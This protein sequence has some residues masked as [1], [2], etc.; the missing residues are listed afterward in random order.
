MPVSWLIVE[1]MRAL[2]I[3]LIACCAIS[4][5]T[6]A[7][8]Q[9][10]LS[11]LERVAKAKPSTGT[12]STNPVISWRND[13]EKFT[14]SSGTQAPDAAAAQWMDLL[15]RFYKLTAEQFNDAIGQGGQVGISTLIQA[16][17]PT[18]AWNK[19]GGLLNKQV[20]DAG[21]NRS[22]DTWAVRLLAGIINND[23]AGLDKTVTDFKEH[24]AALDDLD[25]YERRNYEMRID[26]VEDAVDH[27]AG[28][29]SRAVPR[30]LSTLTKLEKLGTREIAESYYSLDV[31]LLE[32]E[33]SAEET[34]AALKRFLK[35]GLKQFSIR[36]DSTR[37]LA[38]E[39]AVE[40]ADVLTAAPWALVKELGNGLLFEKLEKKFGAQI[41]EY[42]YIQAESDYVHYLI[43]TNRSQEAVDRIMASLKRKQNSQISL[44][45]YN[46]KSEDGQR[47]SVQL[48]NFL[49]ALL[50][51]KPEAPY[52]DDYISLSAKHQQSERAL[53]DLRVALE[54]PGVDPA[55]QRVLKPHMSVAL[56]AADERE[57]GIQALVETVKLGA[58]EKSLRE[59]NSNF[60]DTCLQLINLGRLLQRPELKQ[61]ALQSAKAAFINMNEYRKGNEITSLCDNLISN[62]YLEEAEAILAD[63]LV[64][65]KQAP[66]TNNYSGRNEY[67]ELLGRLLRIYDQANRG[68]ELLAL[69][70]QSPDWSR[71]DLADY[72]GQNSFSDKTLAGVGRAL[73]KADRKAEAAKLA[74][75]LVWSRPALDDGYQL[76]LDT[77]SAE[78]A[79]KLLND[80]EKRDRFQERPLI[81]R[82]QLLLN[83]NKLAE[84]EAEVQRATKI[85][86]SDGEQGKGDRMRAYAVL[87][88][89]LERK[90]DAAGA[91]LMTNIIKAI[92]AS[93]EADDWWQAGLL[94]E[95]VRKY[96]DA[97]KSFSDAY[98]VQ[99]R[100]ALRFA[101]LGDMKMA[102]QHYIKAFELMPSSF[103][104][105][106]SHCFGCE[107]AF[108][109]KLAQEIAERVFTRLQKEQPENPQ[110]HY[111][112]GYLRESQD[113]NQEAGNAYRAAI[114]LDRYYYN[115]L[116][117]LQDLAE[118][119]KLSAAEVD[120]LAL[121]RLRL[122]PN[123]TRG[124][125][126]ISTPA[127]LL[128]MWK[129]ILDSEK[130]MPKGESGP[131]LAL[132]EA[133]TKTNT[134]RMGSHGLFPDGGDS[135]GQSTSGRSLIHENPLI[136]EVENLMQM[137]NNE[138]F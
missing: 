56:L 43:V 91:K 93:E 16:L 10:S 64:A 60:V 26:E 4:M 69:L 87:G 94:K 114:R 57:A 59:G 79:H 136:R 98:C 133:I 83:E 25:S 17:P 88:A 6:L 125:V 116:K 38:G 19:L 42:E 104:R 22:M 35:L 132:K 5:I 121:E 47:Q 107:G 36:H 46:S 34:K 63:R 76:L 74:R 61:L 13:V 24:I 115:A 82:A 41:E 39:V 78:D 48:M 72:M 77:H 106:E 123:G 49:R 1:H 117:N 128:L 28:R 95:A 89:I 102:E 129:L 2:A 32:K 20:S 110:V 52:W 112:L 100:L 105:I 97:L 65:L 103:G 55:L 67:D 124:S 118:P 131:L 127:K 29:P 18:E 135:M 119:L 86:P 30:F 12:Q 75:R 3:F 101:E 7:D 21:K 126:V 58:D 113:R 109:S 44:N 51:T 84:A 70:E 11:I 40:M 68:N 111:L 33:L 27:A 8:F 62:G 73:V 137:R 54:K 120:A 15:R 23:Q 14:S 122:D 90:G 9:G 138:G 45:I 80:V 81:W 71:S 130:A 108:A 92:R 85:D 31:P 53:K 96:Q 99:S 66:Q 37:K 50:T 134:A